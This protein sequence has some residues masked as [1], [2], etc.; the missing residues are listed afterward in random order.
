MR[1]GA[2]T[3]ASRRGRRGSTACSTASLRAKPGSTRSAWRWSTRDVVGYLTNRLGIIAWRRPAPRG[4]RRA[5]RRARSSS[6]A[7]RARARRSSTTCSPRTRDLRAPLSWEVDHPC[8]PPETRHL[9]TPI[10]ASTESQAAARHG[11]LAH[12]RLHAPST[13]WAP[14]SPQECVRI[15]GGDFRSMIFPTQYPAADLQPLAAARGRPGP[16]VPLAPAV[17]AAPAV[18]ASR[19]AVAAQVARPTSGTSARCWP[20]TPTRVVVQTH[21]DPLKVI[22]SVSALAAHLRRMASDDTSIAESAAEFTP[23][24]SSWA[25]TVGMAARDDGVLPPTRSSTCSSPTSS[26]TPSPPSARS[27]SRLGRE[28]SRRRGGPDAGVPRRAPR[29]RGRRRRALPLR[30]HRARSPTR[31]ASGPVRIRSASAWRPRRW[32]DGRH[33]TDP[34]RHVSSTGVPARSPATTSTTTSSS[35]VCGRRRTRRAPRTVS[36]GRSSWCAMRHGARES[37]R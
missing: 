30:R 35:S 34:R 26:P 32:S 25:S 1:A 29:R 20:S 36:H 14:G 15:T 18:R 6:S 21:R 12:P 16:G 28:L 9:S 27:T 10:R 19:A 11:R 5:R 2:T 24:T 13:R 7:S 3:S 31:S 23:T 17:P 33:S 8:P 37:A 22:A 4:G